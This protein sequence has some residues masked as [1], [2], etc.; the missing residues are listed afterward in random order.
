MP[1]CS[2]G[3]PRLFDRSRQYD[4]STNLSGT[5]TARYS[6]PYVLPR[7]PFE[8]R[9][10]ALSAHRAALYAL[11]IPDSDASASAV[12]R[13]RNDVSYTRLDHS[14]SCSAQRCPYPAPW[15]Y[16]GCRRVGTASCV[17]YRSQSDRRCIL[18]SNETGSCLSY[19]PDYPALT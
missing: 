2:S 1:L 4:D 16:A 17:A 8:T 3:T 11:Q 10:R 15:L 18:L 14:A 13:K 5:A 19:R 9:S 7:S 6:S 12:L